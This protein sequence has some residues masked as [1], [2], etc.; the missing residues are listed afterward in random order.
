M[1]R[2][3]KFVLYNYVLINPSISIPFLLKHLYHDLFKLSINKQGYLIV[4]AILQ[5]ANLEILQQIMPI[6]FSFTKVQNLTLVKNKYGRKVIKTL[7]KINSEY[8]LYIN[9]Q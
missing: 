7:S 4:N 1:Q 8:N 3:G 6:F 2:W 9:Q 5:N